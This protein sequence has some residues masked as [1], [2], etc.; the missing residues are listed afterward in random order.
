MSEN[1]AMLSMHNDTSP[2]QERRLLAQRQHFWDR[3]PSRSQTC[4]VD[5]NGGRAVSSDVR[6]WTH[7]YRRTMFDVRWTLYAYQH[8]CCTKKKLALCTSLRCQPNESTPFHLL[9]CH[10]GDKLDACTRLLSARTAP[11]KFFALYSTCYRSQMPTGCAQLINPLYSTTKD[12]HTHVASLDCPACASNHQTS[13][14]WSKPWSRRINPI[15]LH[16]AGE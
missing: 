13:L 15:V 2:M 5:A 11:R 14:H 1:A 7:L 12:P 16:G 6:C 10:P 3:M 4:C 8:K 9:L